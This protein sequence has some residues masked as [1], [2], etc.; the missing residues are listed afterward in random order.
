MGLERLG[1]RD[2]RDSERET[3]RER[4]GESPRDVE[5]ATTEIEAQSLLNPS[6]AAANS[7]NCS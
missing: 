5:E 4:L 3:R 1:E 7:F 2:S 6:N